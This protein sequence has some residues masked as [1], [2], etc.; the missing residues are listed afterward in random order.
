MAFCRRIYHPKNR[1]QL[2]TMRKHPI[3]R[4]AWEKAQHCFN[5]L[6][7]Y[8]SLCSED[9]SIKGSEG[10]CW[11]MHF[12]HTASAYALRF[13]EPKRVKAKVDRDVY[14]TASTN[15]ANA[16]RIYQPKRALSTIIVEAHTHHKPTMIFF[17]FFFANIR[18]L[19]SEPSHLFA[20]IL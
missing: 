17:P 13:F 9:L 11:T 15:L 5:N 12:Q 4:Y 3:R 14:S 7:R 20:N 16:R 18:L 19:A 10:D 1:R 2:S 6:N 8:P